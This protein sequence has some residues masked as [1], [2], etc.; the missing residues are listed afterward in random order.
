MEKCGKCTKGS[1]V[2]EAHVFDNTTIEK[3]ISNDLIHNNI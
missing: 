2:D 3:I 1:K